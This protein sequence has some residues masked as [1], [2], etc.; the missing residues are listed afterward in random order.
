M[1]PLVFS[2]TYGLIVLAVMYRAFARI[3]DHLAADRA[4]D[5]RTGRRFEAADCDRP[6]PGDVGRVH[7]RGK[8][9][10]GPHR[11]ALF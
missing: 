7:H 9:A 4:R 6:G 1:P 11:F 2:C 3:S 5:E 8:R 10:G